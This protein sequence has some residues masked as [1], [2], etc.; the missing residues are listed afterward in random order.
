MAVTDLGA[1]LLTADDLL[2]LSGEGVRGELIRGVLCETMPT[3]REHG[4]IV[5][6]LVSELRAFVKPRRLGIL[7][8]SD[9]GVWLE[10]DPD[11]VR[12]PDIAFFSVDRSPLDGRVT[13]YA[14]V[15]PN[16]V[17]EI[18][19]PGDSRRELNDKARMWLSFGV[20]LV[21]VVHPDRRSVDVHRSNRPVAT[22]TDADTLDGQHVLPGFTCKVRAFFDT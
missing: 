9:S 1:R 11:T 10:R 17:V 3:G 14:E 20:E 6:N 21:W 2:R 13:G 15:A 8:A 5:V 22:A 12:E 4:Q 7:T 18:A 16:L 19:S